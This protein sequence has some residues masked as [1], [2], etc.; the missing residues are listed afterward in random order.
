VPEVGVID[1]F[2]LVDDSTEEEVWEPELLSS[3]TVYPFLA[4]RAMNLSTDTN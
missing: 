4:Q 3:A 1:R 2:V